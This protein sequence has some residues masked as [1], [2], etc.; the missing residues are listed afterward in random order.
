MTKPVQRPLPPGAVSFDPDAL[1]ALLKEPVE[2][3][4]YGELVA[5]K[6]SANRPKR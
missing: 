2:R 1:D 5:P 6:R 4:L 3:T